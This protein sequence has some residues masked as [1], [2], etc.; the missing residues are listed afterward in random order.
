MNTYRP[1]YIE[2]GLL[3]GSGGNWAWFRL[4]THPYDLL[5][6]GQRLTLLSQSTRLLEGLGDA[7]AHLL[8][9]P[10]V[11]PAEAQMSALDYRTPHPE[12]GWP[13]YLEQLTAHVAGQRLEQRE[14]YLGV[15]LAARSGAG[16]PG[17]LR[18]LSGMRRGVRP[19]A[20]ELSRLRKGVTAVLRKLSAPGLGVRL[21]AASELRWLVQRA[22][23]RGLME[24]VELPEPPNRP[25]AD[26]EMIALLEGVIENGHRHLC[27]GTGRRRSHLSTL[28]FAFMPDEL[29][30]PGN[31]EWL[32][33]LGE[34]DFPV[35][36][37]VRFQV[38]PPRAA[39]HDVEETVL[40]AED[41]RKHTQELGI[42][43]P[44]DVEEA[45]AVGQQLRH[46]LTRHQQRMVY[47]WP[48]LLIAAGTEEEME[49]RVDVVEAMF[50]DMGM[51]LTRPSGDQLSLFLEAMPGDHVRAVGARRKDGRWKGGAYEQRMATVTLAGTMWGASGE[52]GDNE[53]CPIG[54]TLGGSRSVVQYDPLR[55]ARADGSG[56]ETAVGITGTLGSGKSLLAG[57]LTYQSRL[58]GAVGV[59]IDPAVRQEGGG[60]WDRMMAL[61]GLGKV[62]QVRLD[63]SY[64]GLL[65]P[66]QIEPNAE[67]AGLLATDLLMSFLPDT[68]ATRDLE[69]AM[70][71]AADEEAK[72]YRPSLVGMVGRLA[73]SEDAPTRR[74]AAALNAMSGMP[75]ARMVF[76]RE[77]G[78]ELRLDGALTLFQF[79]GLDLPAASTRREDYTREQRLAV[80]LMLAI[81]AL[82]SQL[83]RCG[84][85]EQPKLLAIDEAWVLTGNARA[86][87][88]IEEVVRAGRKHNLAVLLIS[89]SAFDFSDERVRN[90]LGA[91]MAFRCKSEAE[92]VEVCRLLGVEPTAELISAVR[93]FEAGDCLF[94]DLDGRVGRIHVDPIPEL[95]AVLSTTPAERS[96]EREN[97]A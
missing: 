37:S 81:T 44:R 73:Q 10:R 90:C 47:A 60:G 94:R 33:R 87:R 65:D 24:D 5:S 28:A 84:G 70:F 49:E 32:S 31:A 36:A 80:G 46:E 74:A 83:I 25:A 61:A 17:L 43:E 12:E 91:I 45:L 39:A 88:M 29:G 95:L 57:S 9:V 85:P 38:V 16:V 14:V 3:L 51:E 35:E 82:S 62:Q 42:D 8:V 52:L 92:M 26:G 15:A 22:Q 48:R 20:N 59:V 79:D 40:A 68:E 77:P 55:A 21:A 97:V 66:W 71:A 86:Q 6:E 53:G 58:R 23:I 67:K 54:Y 19:H 56:R 64:A 93:A 11:Y 18:S 13:D 30:F 89:Q 50:A 7:E 78:R 75:L 2:D 1:T 34:L 76:A 72:S 96:A 4:G 63:Q 69:L 27:L 41:M